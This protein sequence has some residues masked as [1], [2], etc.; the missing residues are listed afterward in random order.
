MDKKVIIGIIVAIVVIL[1]AGYF[2]LNTGDKIL[3]AE[4]LQVTVPGNYTADSEFSAHAG[5][6][7]VSFI[8]QKGSPNND[9]VN[10]FFKAVKVNG[11]DAGYENV[12]NKTINGTNAYEIAAHPDKLKNV[13]TEREATAEGEAWT[14]Y[15]PEYAA[16]F[17]GEVD[18]FRSVYYVKDDK[19]YVLTFTANNAS[20]NLYTPEIDGII[21]S[22][23][24]AAKK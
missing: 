15:P 24:P 11:K 23:A 7:N 1:L 8:E 19:V 21:N 4:N 5:D 2:I 12:T 9:F 3:V 14:T 22:L 18:H 6:L 16:P 20:T 17:G 13:S 10:K